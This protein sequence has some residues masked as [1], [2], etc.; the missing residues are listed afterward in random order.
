MTVL[1]ELMELHPGLPP[2]RQHEYSWAISEMPTPGRILD[3]GCNG[4]I[5][6][7]YLERRGFECVCVDILPEGGYY[8]NREPRTNFLQLDFANVGTRDMAQFF[9]KFDYATII[10]TL[11]HED[12]MTQYGLLLN[13]VLS[14]KKTGR[15]LIT[16]PYGE[17]FQQQGQWTVSC[18]SENKLNDML[19]VS[20]WEVVR[21]QVLRD[22]GNLPL[23]FAAMELK[24]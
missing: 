13:S 4:S 12:L 18:F 8:W 2:T 15:L 5:L 1:D 22:V 23:L 19:A 6:D 16:V 3:V 21:S 17:G 7:K 24:R 20:G 10:S 14:L 11:E 9:H